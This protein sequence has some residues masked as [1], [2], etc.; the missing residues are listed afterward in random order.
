MSPDV[1]VIGAGFAGLSA[2][3]L[4]A[5][6]GRRVL[7][8][9]ARPQLGGRATAFTDRDTGE[10]VDNGQHVLF[11]CYRE[12]FE[13]L[14]RIGAEDNVRRAAGDVDAVPRSPAAGDRSCAVRRCRRRCTCWRRPRLGRAAAGAIGCRCCRWR[15]RCR[16]AAGDRARSLGDVADR[17]AEPTVSR[18]ARAGTVRGERLREWLWDPLAVAA[19]NQSPDEAAAAPFVRVLAELFGPDASR[20]RARA[21]DACR[22]T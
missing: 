5:E 6:A 8:L 10:L 22:C 12:T 1:V 13:F 2:A 15:D 17:A 19:L 16:R 14:R 20:R 9:D 11:G 4:L 7:V 21:A 18:V 3:A